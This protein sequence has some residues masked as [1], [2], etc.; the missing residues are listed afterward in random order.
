M[1]D[2]FSAVGKCCGVGTAKRRGEHD[3]MGQ[4]HQNYVRETRVERAG[5]RS[6]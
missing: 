1:I 3:T 2:D 5:K 4:R 6:E